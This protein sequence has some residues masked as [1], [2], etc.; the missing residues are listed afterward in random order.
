MYQLRDISI[1]SFLTELS[2]SSFFP[3]VAHI[4]AFFSLAN[5]GQK[6]RVILEKKDRNEHSPTA[7]S[8]A[9]PTK[10]KMDL[11]GVGH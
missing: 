7:N 11:G 6:M 8:P 10:Y 2:L 9:D 4:Q 5:S 1:L 3:Q